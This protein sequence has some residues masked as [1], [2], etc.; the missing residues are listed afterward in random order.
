MIKSSETRDMNDG[1]SYYNIAMWENPFFGIEQ[2]VVTCQFRD[3]LTWLYC[4]SYQ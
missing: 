2:M 1:S 4:N 3:F